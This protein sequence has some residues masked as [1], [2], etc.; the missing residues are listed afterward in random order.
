MSK[1]AVRLC[2]LAFATSA[3]CTGMV[4]TENRKDPDR[5][6]D[7]D[8]DVA[9]PPSV[10]SLRR[11]PD[12]HLTCDDPGNLNVDFSAFSRLTNNEY[13]R[14]LRDLAHPIELGAE[15][16][17]ELPTETSDP[18]GYTN[19][20]E[21]Q[22]VA[23]Q[24]I[25]Q[26][27]AT[28]RGVAKKIVAGLGNM[29]VKECTKVAE[30]ASQSGC[31]AAFI[32]SFG[33]RAFRRPLSEE[34]TEGLTALYQSSAETWG[35]ADALTIVTSAIL[36]SPQF[37]YRI[38]IGADDGRGLRLRGHEVATRLSYL[39]W[40]T[41]PDQELLEASA[42]G[43]ME[44]RDGLRVQAERLLDDPRAFIGLGDFAERW[45][46]LGRLRENA[47]A[48]R[49]DRAV[50]PD[51]S[52]KVFRASFAGLERFVQESLFGEKGGVR[53]L[54]SSTRAWVNEDSARL[55]DLEATGSELTEVALDPAR[56]R[57]LLTQAGLLAGFAHPTVQAPVQRGVFLLEHILCSPP[58]PP[59]AD[60]SAAPSTTS[61]EA[62]TTRQKFVEIHENQ[63]GCKGCHVRIDAAGFAFE[64]YDATGRWQ[65]EEVAGEDKVLLPIDASGGLSGTYDADGEYENAVALIDR[66]AV[67]D[68]AAQCFVNNFFHYAMARNQVKSDGCA[69]ARLG[70][71]V[72][73]N[74]GSFQSLVMA[75][76]DADQ[77]QYRAPIDR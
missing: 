18:H 1:E 20:F 6:G 28:G 15:V 42:S 30:A 51:Y 45:L 22:N 23:D 41:T 43:E 21:F 14:S 27:E 57:G 17:L 2:L 29:N 8:D 5:P 35:F 7:R 10:E 44:S 47:S 26:Y 61:G 69:L 72:I 33:G 76:I 4:G 9:D 3:G 55:Y 70:D 63:A 24:G 40:G 66:L 50:F 16:G 49:K 77:F 25:E 74:D 11:I 56:R 68:Q 36:T 12:K 65:D 37:L 52:D 62:Q 58:P 64:N 60:L 31:A 73:A 38:E 34:E 59:P 54:L 32:Q 71:E 67:S 53:E 13:I 19:N 46:A 39:I 75:L 48:A